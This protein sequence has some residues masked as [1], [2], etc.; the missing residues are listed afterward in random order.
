LNK[1]E[2]HDH[3]GGLEF[4]LHEV[5]TGR[6]QKLERPLVNNTRK[7]AKSGTIIITGEE[8]GANNSEEIMFKPRA[9][10]SSNSG[11]CFFIVMK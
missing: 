2:G 4:T 3:V 8:K 6:D 9:T 11:M 1:F 5:V 10:L 7:E